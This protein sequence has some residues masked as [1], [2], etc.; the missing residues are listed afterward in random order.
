MNILN[1]IEQA[2]STDVRYNHI[3]LGELELRKFHSSMQYVLGVDI[4]S[5]AIKTGSLQ[6]KGL[7]IIPIDMPSFFAV[8]NLLIGKTDD[9]IKHINPC[10]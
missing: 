8:G 6:Y 4:S 5:A 2:I 9:S 1:T 3:L 10:P 7:T